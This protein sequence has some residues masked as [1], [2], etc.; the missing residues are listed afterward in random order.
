MIIVTGGTG[1]IGSHLVDALLKKGQEV[2]II[3]TNVSGFKENVE[4]IKDAVEIVNVDIRDKSVSKHLDGAEM[5]Y[6][7]AAD[8]DVRQSVKDPASSFDINVVGSFN[9]LEAMRKKGI[10]KFVFASSGGSIYG[11]C[12]RPVTEEHRLRPISPYG[13]SKAAFDIYLPAYFHDYGI[14]SAAMRYGN[15]IG[16]RS[17]HGVTWDF[18]WKLKK[19]PDELEILGNGMQEKSF[20]HVSDCVRGTVLAGEN[21]KGFRAFNVANHGTITIKKLAETMCDELGITPRFKFTGGER[22]W[23]GD[24]KI[25]RLNTDALQ[26]L[27]WEPKY[28]PEDAVRSQVKWMLQEYGFLP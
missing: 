2:K 1:F 25:T 18:F 17:R 15:I 19:N 27:G 8:P 3:D 11:D 26:S 23:V 4:H 6:H 22:G 7:L 5:V 14:A 20:V 13:A 12:S 16:P 21:L 9:V 10:K 24:T 28:A